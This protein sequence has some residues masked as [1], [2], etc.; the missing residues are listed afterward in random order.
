MTEQD[1]RRREY[2]YLM[3]SPSSP[4]VKIGRSVRP[5]VRLQEVQEDVGQTLALMWTT[6]GGNEMERGLHRHFAAQRVHGEWFALGYTQAVS[7]VEAAI[8]ANTWSA[9]SFPSFVRRPPVRHS[10]VQ[11][12][13][14]YYMPSGG[15]CTACGHDATWHAEDSGRCWVLGEV[16]WWDCPCTAHTTAPDAQRKLRMGS[17]GDGDPNPRVL[18]APKAA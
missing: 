2:V 1:G 3:G 8:A 5:S 10:G 15:Q 14:I 17:Y 4:N 6:P 7:L 16:E 18:T 12:H 11:V 13:G 9:D